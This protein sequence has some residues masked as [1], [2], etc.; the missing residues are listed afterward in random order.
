MP[1]NFLDDLWMYPK[2]E[3]KGRRTMAQVMKANIRQAA[4]SQKGFQSVK[5]VLCGIQVRS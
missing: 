1:Q 3:Q 5:D 4:F 2:A